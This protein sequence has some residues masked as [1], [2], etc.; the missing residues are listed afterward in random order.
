MAEQGLEIKKSGGTRHLLLPQVVL[1]S[2][3]KPILSSIFLIENL[4]VEKSA[5]LTNLW[6]KFKNNSVIE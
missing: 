5:V 3:A 4:P 2:L 6:L 1:I